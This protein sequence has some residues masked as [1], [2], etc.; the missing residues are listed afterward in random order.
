[1]PLL[2]LAVCIYSATCNAK[3]CLTL[4]DKYDAPFQKA[5]RRYWVS[6]LP[7]VPWVALKAQAFIESSLRSDAV[8]PGGAVGL[9]QQ[10]PGTFKQESQ[11]IGLHDGNRRNAR[12]SIDVGASYM[13]S[14]ARFWIEPRPIN[15]VWLLALAGYNSGSGNWY[16]VQVEYGGMYYSDFV[17]HI[18]EFVGDNNAKTASE[19]P[20]KV[21][22]AM[23]RINACGRGK[24]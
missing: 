12:D 19:Y 6:D 24:R 1:M 23:L 3:P 21:V 13:A 10:L 8:S 9:L 16:K 2:L 22:D 11:R 4:T 15:E 20:L 14:R 17:G 18:G 7:H 5:V